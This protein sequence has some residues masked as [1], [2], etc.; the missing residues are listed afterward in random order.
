MIKPIIITASII[1]GEVVIYY[2]GFYSEKIIYY[3]YK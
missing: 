3:L 2:L 1:S